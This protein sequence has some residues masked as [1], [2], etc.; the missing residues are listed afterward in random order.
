MHKHMQS[1]LEIYA[2]CLHNDF[3]ESNVELFAW[4]LP[5]IRSVNFWEFNSCF[6]KLFRFSLKVLRFMTWIR[7][8]IRE[9]LKR[10]R[11][12]NWGDTVKNLRWLLWLKINLSIASQSRGN[13]Q[14]L[15]KKLNKNFFMQK[16][17]AKPV[18]KHLFRVFVFLCPTFDI[19]Q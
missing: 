7:K 2:R 10:K 12:M 19:A 13:Q 14:M 16:L 1:Q 15:T 17:R 5:V 11:S 8:A 18:V 3:C 9:S 6:V 4:Q